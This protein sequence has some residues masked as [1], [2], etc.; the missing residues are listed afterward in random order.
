MQAAIAKFN[1]NILNIRSLGGL[2]DA[3][4]GFIAPALDISDILRSELVLVVSA[5]DYYI[6]EI[7]EEGM[8]EIYQNKRPKTRMFLRFNISIE[9]V[10]LGLSSQQN[11]DW[12]RNEIHEILSFKSFQNPDK[13]AEAVKLI[14]EK[15]LWNEVGVSLGMN[16]VD[17]KNQLLQ[18]VDRR[19]KIAH[20]AD[21][22]PAFPGTRWPITAKMVNDAVNFIE[23]TVN[24]IHQTVTT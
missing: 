21:Q 2:Y 22:N 4:K 6:H 10:I 5:L 16:P 18:I 11:V 19:N 24:S 12:L 7:T 1:Q 9:C 3:L 23:R 13:I 20:E 15:T 17:V 14:S 8:I